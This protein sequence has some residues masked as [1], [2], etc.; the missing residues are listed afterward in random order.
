MMGAV[1]LEQGAW[2]LLLLAPLVWLILAACERLHARRLRAAVGPRLEDLAPNRT[3]HI[4]RARRVLFATALLLALFA[5]LGPA[6]D[7][8]ASEVDWRGVDLV[9][10][11]DISRSMLAGDL[12]P[13]RLG[14]AQ[15]EIRALAERAAGDRLGLVVFAGEARLVSPLTSDTASFAA[16]ADLAHP[17]DVT[18]GGTDLAA[19]LDTATA[20]LAG[21]RSDFG[22]ILLLTDGEDLAGRGLDAARRAKAAGVVVHAVGYASVRGSKINVPGAGFLRDAAGND[23]ISALDAEGLTR[24]AEAADGTFVRAD[25]ASTL[26]DLYDDRILPMARAALSRRESARKENG[27]QWPLAAAFLLWLVHVALGSRRRP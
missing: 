9:V 21:R 22:G 13:D 14:R 26:V 11:L 18:R 1:F 23:V 16:L 12:T 24:I 7:T 8:A 3:P 5:V 25:D 17:T 6:V 15:R 27:Y 4:R 20:A 19:A 2:P 10:C